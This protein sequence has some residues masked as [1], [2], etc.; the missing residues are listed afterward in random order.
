MASINPEGNG[1]FG[2]L[3]LAYGF[4]VIKKASG[5]WGMTLSVAT[6]VFT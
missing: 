1:Y 2:G 4:P 5:I 6:S 3:V